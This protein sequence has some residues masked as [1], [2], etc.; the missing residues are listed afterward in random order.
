MA[1]DQMARAIADADS[2]TTQLTVLALA[3]FQ[4]WGS[5]VAGTDAEATAMR[6]AVE[7]ILFHLSPAELLISPAVQRRATHHG[8]FSVVHVPADLDCPTPTGGTEG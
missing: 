6:R 4:K 2:R 5:P 8:R 3:A 1:A 7:S